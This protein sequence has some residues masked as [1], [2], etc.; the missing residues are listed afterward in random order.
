M[1]KSLPLP[2]MPIPLKVIGYLHSDTP[3]GKFR[4]ANKH[5][6]KWK[7][8]ECEY[9][10]KKMYVKYIFNKKEYEEDTPYVV[11]NKNKDGSFDIPSGYYEHWCSN[12]PDCDYWKKKKNKIPKYQPNKGGITT[13]GIAGGTDYTPLAYPLILTVVVVIVIVLLICCMISL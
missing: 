6:L 3:Y 12:C 10:G 9:I 1:K 7:D 2:P 13:K 4:K 8:G 11:F 5:S